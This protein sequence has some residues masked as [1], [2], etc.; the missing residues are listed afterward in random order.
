MFQRAFTM[1]TPFAAR[2][3]GQGEEAGEAAGAIEHS[4]DEIDNLK[5]QLEEMQ[6][7]LDRLSAAEA[8][9]TKT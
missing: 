3:E 8:E 7:R 5:R 4:A 6:K 9:K 1:F 2:P